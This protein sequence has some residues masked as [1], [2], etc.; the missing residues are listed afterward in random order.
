MFHMIYISISGKT[1]KKSKEKESM[2]YNH[3]F[4]VI[5]LFINVYFVYFKITL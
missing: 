4:Y 5:F 3:L 2:W 1:F